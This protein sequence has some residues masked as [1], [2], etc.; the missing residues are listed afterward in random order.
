SLAEVPATEG[1]IFNKLGTNALGDL[2]LTSRKPSGG[3]LIRSFGPAPV[4]FETPPFR[5][6]QITAQYATSVGPGEA[7]VKAQVNPRFW[8]DTA[9]HV[10]YGTSLCSEG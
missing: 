4:S 6:P 10:E 3:T 5:A 1:D 7:Q 9:Y 8:N 2:Y